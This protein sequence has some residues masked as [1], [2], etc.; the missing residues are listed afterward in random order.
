[1]GVNKIKILNNVSNK[2]ITF[3]LDM[4]TD[5]Y[6]RGDTINT[7]IDKIIEKVIGT[8]PDYELQRFSLGPDTVG[9]T[10]LNYEFYFNGNLSYLENFTDDDVRFYSNRF[11][12]SFF[13]LDLY[14]SI[15]SNAQKIY[16]SIILPVKN[17]YREINFCNTFAVNVGPSGDPGNIEYTN[18]C[19]DLVGRAIFDG[20]EIC[21]LPNTTGVWENSVGILS[22]VTFGNVVESTADYVVSPMNVNCEC[23]FT[24]PQQLQSNLLLP[25]FILDHSGIQEGYFIYWYEDVTLLNLS[26]LYMSAKFFDG[27]DGKYTQFI[28]EPQSGLATPYNPPDSKLYYQLI[29]NY[30]DKTY[31]FFNLTTSAEERVIKWYEFLNP[32]V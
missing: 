29:F 9:N 17:S 28:N 12:K 24:S 32:T 8:P 13:K 26:T 14:D 11:A 7:E 31:R 3:P 23:E 21:V 25:R 4:N 6:D 30:S 22:D 15:E 27:S 20:E 1:M 16:L 5:I 19:G 2:E 10:E 18:C